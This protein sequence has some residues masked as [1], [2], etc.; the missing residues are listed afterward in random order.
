MDT[1]TYD[2][3]K[4]T[5]TPLVRKAPGPGKGRDDLFQRV[6]DAAHAAG[7]QAGKDAMPTPMVVSDANLDGSPRAGGKRYFVSEGVCG[8]AWVVVRPGNHPFANWLKKNGLARKHY[9]GGVSTSVWEFNQSYTRKM[10]YAGAFARVLNELLGTYY[11][12]TLKIYSDGR[13]D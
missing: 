1:K 9:Y 7:L 3:V 5:E 6:Y 8:F 13:L 11:G 10:K 12:D 2:Q 4:V